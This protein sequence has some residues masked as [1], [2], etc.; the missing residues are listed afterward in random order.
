MLSISIPAGARA[1]LI[2]RAAETRPIVVVTATTREAD[3][4]AFALRSYLPEH[5]VAVFPAWETLPH[6]RLS[7]RADTVARRLAVLRRLAHPD[8]ADARTDALRV[9]IMPVR[10]LLQPVAVGLGDLAPVSLRPGDD[11]VELGRGDFA[12]LLPNLRD[13][14]HALLAA[15]RLLRQFEQPVM[16]DG[17]PVTVEAPLPKPFAVLLK[18]LGE[19]LAI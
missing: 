2:A 6:E 18:K 3:E 8:P 17:Q 16:A 13:G 5:T 1:P 10:A 14:Q 4:V 19:H 12:V 15:A 9:T 11:V 7:P